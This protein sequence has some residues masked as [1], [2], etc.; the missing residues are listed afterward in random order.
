M[1]R[2]LSEHLPI[3]LLAALY[4][5]A[6]YGI[7]RAYHMP[8]MM[9]VQFTYPTLTILTVFLSVCLLVI[10]AIRGKLRAYLN[11]ESIAGF[12]IIFSLLPPFKCAFASIKQIIPRLHDFSWDKD[13]MKLDYVLHFEHH[14]WN[15]LQPILRNE[16]IV[17]FIDTSY[18]LWFPILFSCCILMA[19]ST[20]RRLRLQFFMTTLLIW[21]GLGSILGTIFSSAGP[22]YYAKVVHEGVN[23]YEP[24]MEE[25]TLKHELKPLWAVHNQAG[26]WKAKHSQS[27]LPF[28]GI[29]AMPSIHVAMAVVFALL[30]WQ[31]NRWLGIFMTLY[32]IIIQIGAVILGWHYAVDG[33]A[34]GILTL[35][36]WKFVGI[37]VDHQVTHSR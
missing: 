20:R 28:G 29:S 34:G 27:W 21:I 18:I 23:P 12:L 3:V 4:I 1:A 5:G 32:A 35:I 30:A 2:T 8:G 22:C 36:L 14:P 31:I 11:Q 33:Y 25:L 6:G 7:Q 15:L 19:W 9:S 37:F 17:R 13:L 26:L 16:D 24:L 10:Q